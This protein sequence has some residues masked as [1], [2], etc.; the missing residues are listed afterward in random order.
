MN[1]FKDKIKEDFFLKEVY[2]QLQQSEKYFIFFNSGRISK[3]EYKENQK[4]FLKILKNL[5]KQDKQ[6]YLKV[7]SRYNNLLSRLENISYFRG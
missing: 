3:E 7:I 5:K 4:E 1:F 6:K 2:E